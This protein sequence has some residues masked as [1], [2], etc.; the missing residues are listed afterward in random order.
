MKQSYSLHS[1]T[2]NMYQSFDGGNIIIRMQTS[3]CSWIKQPIKR[4]VGHIYTVV[5]WLFC[6][7]LLV[8]HVNWLFHHVPSKSTSH[9]VTAKNVL[10][11]HKL[12][13]NSSTA[14]PDRNHRKIK[15]STMEANQQNKRS[16]PHAWSAL[17]VHLWSSGT[18]APSA[19]IKY[20]HGFISRDRGYQMHQNNKITSGNPETPYLSIYGSLQVWDRTEWC[21]TR[22]TSCY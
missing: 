17:N 5:R 10:W 3:R 8:H 2:L 15:A 19:Q 22:G 16:P 7:W 13:K 9:S 11:H 4:M 6:F 14:T 1:S 20:F 12:R 21:F 18:T